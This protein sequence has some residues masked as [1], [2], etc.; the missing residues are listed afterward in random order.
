MN[1]AKTQWVNPIRNSDSWIISCSDGIML[2]DI[3]A[4]ITF[5]KPLGMVHIPGVN[6]ETYAAYINSLPA[7]ESNNL[8]Y[9]LP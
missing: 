3:I 4:G 7:V 1:K 2:R 5:Y 8:W 6:D 9:T